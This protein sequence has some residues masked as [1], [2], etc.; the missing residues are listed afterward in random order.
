M[1]RLRGA[2]QE[3]QRLLREGLALWIAAQDDLELAG[4][5]TT[6]P[7]L[8]ALCAAA[9]PDFVIFEAEA[10]DWDALRTARALRA[11]HPRLRLVATVDDGDG[12]AHAAAVEAGVSAVVRR[13]AGVGEVLAAVRGDAVTVDVRPVEP[14][15]QMAPAQLS[16][17]LTER[18]IEIL[19]LIG[20]GLA[21]REI[22]ARLR[23]SPKTVDNH[24]QRMYAKLG[25]QS[26]AHAVAV[27]MRA[28]LI[29][30]AG[31]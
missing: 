24:K 14:Q 2:V 21:A 1:R 5:A 7:E 25:V 22:A 23:I 18:E 8:V 6:G 15:P 29:G 13:T 30:M 9:A 11:R 10:G 20:A 26:Q 31:I 17:L 28:G 3:R 4:S 19:V 27:A 16:S 12:G